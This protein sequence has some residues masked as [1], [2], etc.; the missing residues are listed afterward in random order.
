MHIKLRENVRTGSRKMWRSLARRAPTPLQRWQQAN[1]VRAGS[2]ASVN[3]NAAVSRT[4]SLP[5]ISLDDDTHSGK[6]AQA[7]EEYGCCYLTG[8]CVCKCERSSS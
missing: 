3:S 2:S 8:A 1:R 5:I 4:K 7:F 6:L